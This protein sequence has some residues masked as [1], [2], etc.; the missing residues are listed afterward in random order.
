MKQLLIISAFFLSL[1]YPSSLADPYIPTK[2]EWLEIRLNS[3]VP[4]TV[5]EVVIT[6][7]ISNDTI[8]IEFDMPNNKKADKIA[9]IWTRFLYKRA[10]RIK[11]EYKWSK[12]LI[13]VSKKYHE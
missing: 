10:R 5:D 6:Q 11:M 1:V 7:R 8:I 3:G 13:I 4:V 9:K 2:K 12:N